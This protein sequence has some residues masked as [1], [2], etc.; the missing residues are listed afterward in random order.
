MSLAMSFAF[1]PCFLSAHILPAQARIFLSLPLMTLVDLLAPPA[2]PVPWSL[3]VAVGLS[4]TA[5][6][7][8]AIA[9]A[10]WILEATTVDKEQANQMS[11]QNTNMGALLTKLGEQLKS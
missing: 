2:Q 7:L 9:L 11:K 10:S 3:A 1:T 6:D 5:L 8:L 4:T